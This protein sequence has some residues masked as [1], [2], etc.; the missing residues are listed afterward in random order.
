MIAWLI[1]ACEILFWLFIFA[2]LFARYVLKWKRIGIILLFCT[3]LIDLFLLMATIIDLKNGETAH[4]VHALSA[5]YIGVSVAFGRRMIQWADEHFFYRFVGGSRPK[6][7]PRFGKEHAKYERQGW[8]RHLLA[9]TIGNGLIFFMVLLVNDF[10]K[11]KEL[12]I[13]ATRWS[14]ILIIDFLWSFSYTLWPRRAKR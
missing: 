7:S 2:G 5:V 6:K 3:P 13:A 1:I 11:T 10:D 4:F 9:W 12:L 14:V 8:Y